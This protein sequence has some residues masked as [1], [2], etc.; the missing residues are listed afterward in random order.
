MSDQITSISVAPAWRRALLLVPVVLALVCVWYVARWCLG[1]TMAEWLPDAGVARAAARLAPDDP[2]TH[3]TLARLAEKSFEPEQLA[4]AVAQYERAAA[5]SPNDYR[6]W[7]ELGRARSLASDD[8]GAERALRRAVELAPNYPDPRWYLGNLLL[9]AGRTGDAFA[10]LRRAAQVNP[11]RFRSQVFDV[12]WR[13]SDGSVPAVVAAVG[14]APDTRAALI[15]FLLGRRAADEAARKAAFAEAVKLWQGLNAAERSAHRATGEKLRDAFLAAK[16]YH[17]ALEVQ[18]ELSA[19]NQ[20]VPAAEQLLNGGFEE[21][22]GPA[23]KTWY[24]WQVAPIAQTQINLDE[25]ERHNGA[26]SLRIVFNAAGPLDFRNVSQLVVVAPQTRYRLTYYVRAKEVKGVSTVLTEVLDAA[27]QAR[28]LA[29]SAPLPFGSSDWQEVALE[30]TTPPQTEA[31]VVRLTRPPCPEALCPLFGT[32][33]Y[34]DFNLQRLAGGR[35]DERAA[36]RAAAA[37]GAPAR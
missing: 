7:F 34:D 22:V 36:G 29:A 24:D 3:Y 32:V 19:T 15:E 35:A 20:V 23:G 2:Q 37:T 25:R 11:E 1:N 26:R 33:W 31:I 5:L 28:A 30:F 9:R 8:A 12:A 21:A 18:R 14:D 13:A 4:E 27:D 6:L 10:E 17:A 16:Q